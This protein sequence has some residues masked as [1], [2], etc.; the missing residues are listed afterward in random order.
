MVL[1][2][3]PPEQKAAKT[4]QPNAAAGLSKVPN[5]ESHQEPQKQKSSKPN[6]PESAKAK[7]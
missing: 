5:P 1:T 3:K 6:K 2:R 7:I 4:K